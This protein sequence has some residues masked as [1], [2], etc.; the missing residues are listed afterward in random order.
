[1]GLRLAK[2]CAVFVAGTIMGKELMDTVNYVMVS[3]LL[4]GH[5]AETLFSAFTRLC[6]IILIAV[7]NVMSFT[8]SV[9]ATD[10]FMNMT[11]LS[12]LGD[13]GVFVLDVAK[14]GVLGHHVGKA[15]TE[16]NFSISILEVYPAWFTRI[17][18][19]AVFFQFGFS[20]LFISLLVFVLE[21]P[22]C[23][24]DGSSP[25]KVYDSL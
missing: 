13:L 2:G 22:D 5:S 25:G 8:C 6:T 20:S 14:R 16:L 3:E 15:M 1:M 21:I 17:R 4:M 19:F 24:P 18:N 9:N 7:A 23:N 10:V 11:A 12:F